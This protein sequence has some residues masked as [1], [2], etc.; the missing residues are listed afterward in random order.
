MRCHKRQATPHPPLSRSPFSRR[1]RLFITL[2]RVRKNGRKHIAL[3]H[4]VGR[5]HILLSLK[6]SLRVRT[7][8][9]R[10][11]IKINYSLS[12]DVAYAAVD[13]F[14]FLQRFRMKYFKSTFIPN[15]NFFVLRDH[16]FCKIAERR[17]RDEFCS[18]LR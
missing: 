18:F 5:L 12:S 10:P 16:P 6:L 14:D 4:P 9:V 11:F 7:L 1:R 3:C 15:G 13:I 2:H 17:E 8:L